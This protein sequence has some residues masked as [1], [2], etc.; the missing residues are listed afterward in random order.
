MKI[1]LLFVGLLLWSTA[2]AKTQTLTID[3]LVQIALEHSPDIDAS[4]F[5][6]K[7]AQQRTKFAEGYYL[8][9]LDIGAV[10]GK[11]RATVPNLPTQNSDILSGTVSV[12]QL[13][14]D[15]GKTTGNIHRTEAEALALQAQM[16]QVISD[17]ILLVKQQYYEVLKSKSI[18][19]VQEKNVKLQKQ[20]LNR[21]QKYLASGIKTIIDVSDAQVALEQANLDL[22]NAKFQKEIERA[23]LEEILG[24]VPNN[25]NY[26]LYSKKL[27][28]PHVSQKLPLIK[29]PLKRLED[30]AYTHRYVLQSAKHT[31]EG[32][33]SNVDA[34]T[35]EYAP[36]LTLNG[37]YSEQKDDGFSPQDQGLVTV[38]MNWNLFSG[39][40]TDASVQEAKIAVLKANSQVLSVKL[41][42]KREVIES[43]IAIRRNMQNVK[44]TE[45]IA[46][47]SKQKFHQA[48]KRYEN[49]LS[50]FVE[51]QNAQQGY[52]QSLSNVVNAYYDYYI[53]MAQLDHAIG[54]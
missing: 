37:S 51:L 43:H 6:F 3:T 34:Q 27:S 47:T 38:N 50:D 30:F 54:K 16:Q 48:K 7:G 33:R 20:Q 17:K 46:R 25:G 49:D 24:Y 28:L 22:L 26:R 41:S 40:Q 18:I 4:R 5:D 35:G 39:Y 32:T 2:E 1:R 11:Q 12:A 42:V 13:L 8:P 29:T 45:S 14:Y 9:K 36:T 10:V 31:V 23:K 19:H 53:A 44:L 21:A 15:F 52:I